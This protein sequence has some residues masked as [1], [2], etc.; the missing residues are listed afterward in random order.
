MEAFREVVYDE[1]NKIWRSL[2]YKEHNFANQSLGEAF[3]KSM[4]N[5]PKDKVLE[6]FYDTNEE[7]SAELIY[8]EAI[9]I[10][11]NLQRI[12]IKPGDVVV[13]YS[14]HNPNISVLAFGC[15]LIGAVVTYFETKFLPEHID[16]G[17][18]LVEPTMII[19]EEAYRNDIDESL[20]R[21]KQVTLKYLISIDSKEFP[22]IK[23]ELLK[24]TSVQHME[25]FRTVKI[26]YPKETTAS[27]VYTSGS[28][29]F[30]KAVNLSH[31]AMLSGIKQWWCNA[32][33]SSVPVADSVM[34]A[35]SPLRWI[36]AIAIMLQS[37][38][39]GIKRIYTSGRA[40][41]D[42]IKKGKVTHFFGSPAAFQDVLYTA[43]N[44]NVMS[45]L[46]YALL[47]GEPSPKSISDL[48][49]IQAKN[50]QLFSVYG[51]TEVSGCIT[52][53][54]DMNGGKILAGLE[55]KILDEEL[56]PV[57]INVHGQLCIK[58]VIPFN[59]YL[60]TNKHEYI[61]KD[62]FFLNGDYGFVD[63]N[64]DLHI[65]GR[66]KDLVHTRNVTLIPN[67]IEDLV[68]LL[69]EVAFARLVGCKKSIYDSSETG[70]LF[71]ELKDNIMED[72]DVLR[73]KIRHKLK[74]NL[75]E[76]QFNSINEILFMKSLPRVTCGKIDRVSLR[77]RV[78]V[79]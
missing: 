70:A 9:V 24:P 27:L 35:S 44:E 76:E 34:F 49:K 59:G 21:C 58:P 10:A 3:L 50:C 60:K 77:R 66:Y 72:H 42:I 36:G 41:A 16:H 29:G 46:R 47:G 7:K 55:L 2:N 40:R 4:L 28:T 69:P 51:M 62:N 8:K 54:K 17:L 61:L 30:P 71:I 52:I 18:S 26:P 53:E 68:S 12:G 19:Y 15:Y 75:S 23:S 33:N 63:E 78:N 65:A 32:D 79:G 11:M 57:G 20:K 22:N 39:L 25:S 14:M 37:S 38:I 6:L 56:E 67:D 48:T 13:L 73:N 1:E 64:N 5:M 45:T 43:K 31:A 74:A